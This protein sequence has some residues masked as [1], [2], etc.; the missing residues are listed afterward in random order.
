[1][2]NVYLN[3]NELSLTRDKLKKELSNMDNTLNEVIANLREISF[4]YQGDSKTQ[5]F[6]RLG[7]HVRKYATYKSTIESY[8]NFLD[9]AI[10]K[11]KYNEN[12]LINRVE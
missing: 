6:E 5:A 10:E 7:T 11:Y 3:E 9:Q 12:T 1:M 8:I 4:Y 2:N